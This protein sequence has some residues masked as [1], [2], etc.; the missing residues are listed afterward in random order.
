MIARVFFEKAPQLVAVERPVGRPHLHEAGQ[1]A[2][3]HGVRTVVLV[4]R[5][6]HHDLV[7]GI[8]HG[9]VINLPQIEDEAFRT[10]KLSE[11][12]ALAAR[13]QERSAAVLARIEK[14]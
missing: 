4:E 9:V 5:L 6:Q 14:S 1:G 13:A 12:E 7:A 2:G 3:Q 11:A 10:S 8:E